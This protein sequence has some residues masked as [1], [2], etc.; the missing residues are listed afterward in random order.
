MTIK[1]IYLYNENGIFIEKGEAFINPRNPD[2][3]FLPSNATTIN[4]PSY[5]SN[6]EY[7]KFEEGKWVIYPFKIYYLYDLTTK[8]FKGMGTDIDNSKRFSFGVT[9]KKPI[10]IKDHNKQK[11]YFE[12]DRWIIKELR[13][14]HLYNPIDFSYLKSIES[15]EQPINSSIKSLPNIESENDVIKWNASKKDWEIKVKVNYNKLQDSM[16]NIFKVLIDNLEDRDVQ[17]KFIINTQIDIVDKVEIDDYIDSLRNCL[18]TIDIAKPSLIEITTSIR[19]QLNKYLYNIRLYD[20]VL[21]A[22]NID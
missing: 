1:D 17:L 4:P 9:T 18:Y 2:S 13:T 21:K 22:D 20:L 11:L 15:F 14:Y 10:E 19:N 3:V 12:E 5:N 7:I 16:K 8:E 6:K